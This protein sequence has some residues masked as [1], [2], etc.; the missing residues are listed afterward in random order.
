MIL[1]D[2]NI[3]IEQVR[4]NE[5]ARSW[6]SEA[7]RQSGR[8]VTS[9]LCVTELKG[10]MRS[11]ERRVIDRLLGLVDIVPVD[12]AIAHRAGELMRTYRRSHQGIGIADYVIAATA[13]IHGYELATLNIRDF[14][15]FEDLE[16]PFR[17]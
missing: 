6:L 5:S 16:P 2:T 12:E 11:P 9:A 4:G 8:L 7:R 15:M 3:L 1:L 10:G 17:L 14:P 13:L